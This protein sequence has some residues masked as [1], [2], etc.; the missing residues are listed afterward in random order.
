MRQ[1]NLFHQFVEFI[2]E[3]LDEGVL[4]VSQRYGTAAHKCCCGCGEEVITP[5]TPTDWSLRIEG[6]V[7]TLH[8]SVGNWSFACRSHYWIR[9]GKVIWAGQISQQ[10]IER[11]RVIDRAA[12]QAYFE[13]ANRKK[14]L[15]SQF[16][17]D[18]ALS[19]PQ[20]EPHGLLYSMQL[21]IKRWWNS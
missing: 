7:A 16:F 10:Q 2:P 9:R 15:H 5:L 18:E 21:V 19:P 14:A 13:S 8:P 4:Y 11:G 17:P 20:T 3:R 1:T 6:N 12:K